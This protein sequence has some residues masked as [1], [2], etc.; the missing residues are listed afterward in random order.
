MQIRSAAIK[1]VLILFFLFY[2]SPTFSFSSSTMVIRGSSG[3]PPACSTPDDGDLI[4][5]GFEGSGYEI[6]W[7][8]SDVGDGD[9]DAA[10]PSTDPDQLC[11]DS[12]EFNTTADEEEWI[13]KNIGDYTTTYSSFWL[14]VEQHN[15]GGQV[16]AIYGVMDT[17]QSWDYDSYVN[18]F[19]TGDGTYDIRGDGSVDSAYFTDFTVNTWHYVEMKC[20]D[21]GAAGTSTI[22]VDNGTPETFTARDT[23]RNSGTTYIWTGPFSTARTGTTV[24]IDQISVDTTGFPP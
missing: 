19:W 3:A 16:T 6:S 22:N 18:V 11:D 10:R 21:G 12:I 8:T 15:S 5:E 20:V 1:V 14:L 9:P 7:N 17:Q 13:E 2:I 24:Y 23:G 4:D